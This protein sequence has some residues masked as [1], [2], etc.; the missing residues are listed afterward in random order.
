MPPVPL[1]RQGCDFLNIPVP[2]CHSV[3]YAYKLVLDAEE[4]ASDA[5]AVMH[6][7]VVGHFILDLHKHRAASRLYVSLIGVT[8][9]VLSLATTKAGDQLIAVDNPDI[10]IIQLCQRYRNYVICACNRSLSM[11]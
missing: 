3:A 5:D 10:V 6:I 11:R 2:T 4:R 8:R 1:P 7:R 9:E